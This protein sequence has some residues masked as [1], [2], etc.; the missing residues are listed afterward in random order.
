MGDADGG[1][2]PV[3]V[4]AAVAGGAVGVDAD[5]LGLDGDFDVL[6]LGQDGHGGRA[7]VDAP[8][9][10]RH[11]DPLDAVDP[12][13]KLHPSEGTQPHHGKHRFFNTAQLRAGGADVLGFKAVAFGVAD[14][15]A[16][17]KAR[18]QGGFLPARSGADLDDDAA[19]VV[20]VPGDQV[21]AQGLLQR[22]FLFR[23]QA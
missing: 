19:V 15:H 11:R 8:G 2:R 12:A 10:L 16:G 3:D 5:F 7:G 20:L 4:L 18:E 21:L 6:H 1:V 22:I 23:K 14:V 13:F 17:Q 9:G